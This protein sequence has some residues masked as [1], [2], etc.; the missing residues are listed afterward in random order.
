MPKYTFATQRTYGDGSVSRL[1]YP[2]TWEGDTIEDAMR[3]LPSHHVNPRFLAKDDPK[4][5]NDFL[6]DPARI[7]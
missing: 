3:S 4:M 5:E 2:V 6:R 1:E 7:M